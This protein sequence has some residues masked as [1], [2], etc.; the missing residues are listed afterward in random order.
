MKPALL[1]FF[2]ILFFGCG[3]GLFGKQARLEEEIE[4]KAKETVS[5]QGT[6]LKITLDSTGR[7]WVM[8][9]RGKNTGERPYCIITTKLNGKEEKASLRFGSPAEVGDYVIEVKSIDSFAATSCKLIVKHKDKASAE[10][11][12]NDE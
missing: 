9:E 3:V 8:D 4:L 7:E 2:T 11:R 6:G 10:D 12:S 1:L 5:I